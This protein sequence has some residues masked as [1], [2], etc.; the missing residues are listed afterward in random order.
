[1]RRWWMIRND[2]SY[3][4]Y[5]TRAW[6]IC[7]YLNQLCYM[8]IHDIFALVSHDNDFVPLSSTIEF[9]FFLKSVVVKEMVFKRIV[10]AIKVGRPTQIEWSKQHDTATKNSNNFRPFVKPNII[11]QQ[12]NR[13]KLNAH[14]DYYCQNCRLVPFSSFTFRN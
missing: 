5:V 12:Q 11:I 1:M 6:N 14:N 8:K 10:Y 9:F 13:G 2:C 7:I 4:A 3:G